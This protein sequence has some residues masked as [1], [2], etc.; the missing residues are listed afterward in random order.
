MNE[1]NYLSRRLKKRR[2]EL[3]FTLREL[4]NNT[5]LTPSFISQ[6]ERGVTN[7]SLATLQKLADALKVPVMFFMTEDLSN[8]K[9]VTRDSERQRV[10]VDNA[11]ISYELLTPD[12][13]GSFEGIL[14]YLKPGSKNAVRPLRVETEE[15]YFVIEGE[16][17]VGVG[18][19]E[20]TLKKGDSFHVLGTTVKKLLCAGDQPVT[21]LAVLSPPVL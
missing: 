13:T 7:P 14:I 8:G 12:L 18:D 19:D 17:L 15:L 10:M 4:A 6:I 1:G 2:T 9:R 20:V 16:L 5:S 21:Y 11:D 3:G